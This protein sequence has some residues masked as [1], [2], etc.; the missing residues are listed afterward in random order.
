MPGA[1]VTLQLDKA[2]IIDLTSPAG[3]PA[4][5]LVRR[6]NRVKNKA[7]TLVPV[8]TGVLRSSISVSP[9]TKAGSTIMVRVGS[10]VGYA[11]FVHEG[12]GIYGPKGALI[13]P[14]S[15]QA[16]RWPA[17]N[18]SGK[19]RRRYKAGITE[20]YVFA[21][22]SKGSPANHFLTDALPAAQG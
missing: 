22:W 15:G 11:L 19:G 7:Q 8:N 12:T 16:L 21:K 5:E 6:A 10:G 17:V 3:A 4:R 13:K 9:P 1:I 14:K 20:G 2:A 18:N